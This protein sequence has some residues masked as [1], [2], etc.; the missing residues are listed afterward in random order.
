[1][2]IRVLQRYSWFEVFEIFLL[3]GANFVYKPFVAPDFTLEEND[4]S[5]VFPLDGGVPDASILRSAVTSI[6]VADL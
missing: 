4:V 5:G 1:M 6:L 2:I 3:N